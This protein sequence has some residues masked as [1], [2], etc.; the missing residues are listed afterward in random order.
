MCEMQS[1][2]TKNIG[3]TEQL[4]TGR[5]DVF[6]YQQIFNLIYFY[7]TVVLKLHLS[8]GFCRH[9]LIPKYIIKPCK[10]LS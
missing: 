7:N 9:T 1:I 5:S 2:V 8:A 3:T 6:M 4:V 10:C